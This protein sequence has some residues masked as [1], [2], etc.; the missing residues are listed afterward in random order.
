MIARGGGQRGVPKM[1]GSR[2]GDDVGFVLLW[3]SW[4]MSVVIGE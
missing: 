4:A 3:M 1:I 2:S